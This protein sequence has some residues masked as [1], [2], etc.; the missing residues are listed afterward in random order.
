MVPNLTKT[1]LEATAQA[2]LKKFGKY[3]GRMLRLE[4]SLEVAGFRIEPV[5]G[6]AEIAEAYLPAKS[7]Y[8]YVDEDQYLSNSHRW[9]FTLAEELAHDLIHR[10][11]FAG[12]NSEQ[13]VAFQE[14]LSDEEYETIERQAKRLAGC[15]LMPEV[16]F[17]RRFKHHW[18]T[19]RPSVTSD[20]TLLKYVI[21]QLNFDFAASHHAI[22]V[23]AVY[24]GLIDQSQFDD[25]METMSPRNGS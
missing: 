11:M 5:P 22:A 20:L 17:I 19:Q 4:H 8:I 18:D 1:Q 15:L 10:P 12:M 13:I 2:W 24:L 14:S 9:R 7:N 6:L 16:E 3:D 23:R 25:F 21:R